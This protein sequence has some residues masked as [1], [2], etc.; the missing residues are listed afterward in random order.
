MVEF[1]RINNSKW[2][3]PKSKPYITIQFSIQVFTEEDISALQ[4]ET[5]VMLIRTSYVNVTIPSIST[6]RLLM[7]NRITSL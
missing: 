6:Q 5:Y 7:M 2:H 1:K 4:K 3:R